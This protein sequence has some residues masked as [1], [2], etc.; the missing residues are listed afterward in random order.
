MN[1]S[2][3]NNTQ[4]GAGG[5]ITPDQSAAA[6]AHSSALLKQMLGIN[7][8]QEFD[9]QVQGMSAG[10]PTPPQPNPDGS[11]QT[12]QNPSLPSQL[13]SQLTPP[14]EPVDTSGIESKLQELELTHE[15]EIALLKSKMDNSEL[16][17]QHESD[18]IKLEAKHKQEIETI[19]G[20]V[21]KII[22]G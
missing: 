10:Q 9:P 18:I 2:Q 13:Q 1:N 5:K 17:K 6:L 7:N 15:K 11:A 19:K 4:V 12:P 3:D 14:P 20:E 16:K 21:K 8:P 22:N